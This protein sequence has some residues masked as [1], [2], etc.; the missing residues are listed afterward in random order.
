MALHTSVM[1]TIL[2]RPPGLA[3][4]IRG[5]SCFHWSSVRSLRYASRV[6]SGVSESTPLLYHPTFQTGSKER[7]RE[8]QI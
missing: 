2:G 3:D 5:S 6:I 7:M 4:G 8:N 1:S